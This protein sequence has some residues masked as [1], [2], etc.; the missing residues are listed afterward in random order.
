MRVQD[1]PRRRNTVR[2]REYD[3]ASEGWYFVTMCTCNREML[4]GDVIDGSMLL[5]EF[6]Q[7]IE[8]E[9]TKTGELRRS[10]DL[11][12]FVVL[13]NH[14]HGILVITEEDAPTGSRATQRVAPTRRSDDMTAMKPIHLRAK[15]PAARSLSA[16]I[17]QIKS[18][19]TKRI[20][21]LL[22]TPGVAVWQR[23]FYDHII[24]NGD[25]L[26]RIRTYIDNNPAMWHLDLDNPDHTRR[27]DAL[28][29]PVQ[30]ALTLKE[31]PKP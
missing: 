4:F 20:N 28:R 31:T 16:I 8:D 13:P 12:A 10:I 24:R 11:D 27:G 7:I 2:A 5:N 17:G 26:G 25:E 21:V 23:G 22:G 19:S 1:E 18:A 9:W 3:Y 15:G 30:P 6:G 14:V 29:R